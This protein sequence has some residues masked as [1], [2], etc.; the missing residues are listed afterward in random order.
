MSVP[1]HPIEAIGTR[2]G[3]KLYEVLMS[4]EEMAS[5]KEIGNYFHIKPDHRDLRNVLQ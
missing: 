1:N 2:H 3:E 5:S 4:R